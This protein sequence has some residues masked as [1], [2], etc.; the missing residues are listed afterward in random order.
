MR[1]QKWMQ[2]PMPRPMRKPMRKPMPRPMQKRQAAQGRVPEWLAPPD[3]PYPQ[4]PSRPPCL[5]RSRRWA[6][7]WIPRPQWAGWPSP[8]VARQPPRASPYPPERARQWRISPRRQ[9]YTDL[10]S[11]GRYPTIPSLRL[12][13]LS[14]KTRDIHAPCRQQVLATRDISHNWPD[15][16]TTTHESQEP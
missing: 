6:R 7:V 4:A 8:S 15:F 3:P 13:Y 1:K 11:P 9:A 14:L 5:P 12:P 10:A 16:N 2:R